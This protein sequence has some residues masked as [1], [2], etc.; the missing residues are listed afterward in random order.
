[1]KEKYNSIKRKQAL[2][3]VFILGALG[4]VVSL[5]LSSI[6]VDKPKDIVE[7]YR[8]QKNDHFR[9]SIK[10]PIKDKENFTGLSYFDYSEKYKIKAFITFTQDT[11]VVS[12]LRTDGKRSFYIAFAKASF[13]IDNKLQ[14]L[15]LYKYPDDI[16]NKPLLFVP[17]YDASNGNTTYTGG[18]YLDV[19]LSSNKTIILDFNYAYNPFCVYNYQY[20]CPIVPKE[21]TLDVV[22]NA[23]EK[24]YSNPQ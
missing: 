22:I 10:S 18:R 1:M 21:N 8:E 3:I 16:Q 23:G 20:T 24:S 13:K 14:T 5:L 15:T 19:E 2:R 4:I 7:K 9:K 17:F 11:Q 6:K 12:M